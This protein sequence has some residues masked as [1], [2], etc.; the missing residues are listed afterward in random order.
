MRPN[1]NVLNSN[2]LKT[3]VSSYRNC[4][5]G[6]SA[7][8]PVHDPAYT[9]SFY[10]RI[11]NEY[12]V[13]ME[14]MQTIINT[15]LLTDAKSISRL[16][17]ILFEALSKDKSIPDDAVFYALPTGSTIIKK[18]LMRQNVINLPAFMIGIWYYV[19][20]YHT[21]NLLGRCALENWLLKTNKESQKLGELRDNVGKRITR[22][23]N[24]S[25]DIP[26]FSIENRSSKTSQADP[27][28]VSRFNDYL[29]SLMSTYSKVQTLAHPDY[30]SDVL[31]IYTPT[32]L[33]KADVSDQASQDIAIIKEPSRENI[34]LYSRTTLIAGS[35][36][37]GKSVH[38]RYFTVSAVEEFKMTG[39]YLPIV[40][41]LRNYTEPQE[42]LLMF[43]FKQ[44]EAVW[45]YSPQRLHQY[46]LTRTTLVLLDGVDEIP[47]DDLLNKFSQQLKKFQNDYSRAQIIIS[48]RDI[49]RVY[50]S[51]GY[52]KLFVVP[53]TLNQAKELLRKLNFK[54]EHPEIVEDFIYKLETDYFETRK[55][56][57][58]NPLM[59]TIMLCVFEKYQTLPRR[60]Y[61][62][63]KRLYEVMS[64]DFDETKG[65]YRRK[66]K[67][68][69]HSDQFFEILEELGARLY[70]ADIISFTRDQLDRM[71]KSMDCISSIN[72]NNGKELKT[73]DFIDDMLHC[74]CL[75]VSQGHDTYALIH[76]TFREFFFAS[77]L[78]RT[79]SD[80]VKWGVEVI[81]NN[82]WKRAE[83]NALAMIYDM[84]E[85][86]VKR[87]IFIPLLTQLISQCENGDGVLTYI[88]IVYHG[89]IVYTIGEC[90]GENNNIVWSPILKFILE[91]EGLH[92][93]LDGDLVDNPF[94]FGLET[95]YYIKRDRKYEGQL[96]AKEELTIK[97]KYLRLDSNFNNIDSEDLYYDSPSWVGSVYV[98]N[99]ETL[100][101]KEY[102]GLYNSIVGKDSPFY[103]E[104]IGLKKYYEKLVDDKKKVRPSP[105]KSWL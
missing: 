105:F 86:E 75:F 19:T 11:Q 24:I 32:Y 35:G 5:S 83:D 87:M 46:L 84:R 54:P 52:K 38:I 78:E 4:K 14:E 27:V 51:T 55:S 61:L 39:E 25:L 96:F 58:T 90:K 42:S 68:N 89:S 104:Y 67:T 98:V 30:T 48:S 91:T 95:D 41:E 17:R 88:H 20:A 74:L 33:R 29:E 73:D 94:D 103:K 76:P 49:S 43:L 97:D 8:I 64:T 99:M 63:Y 1:H 62:L 26:T 9:E 13:L 53:L 60:M 6:N 28:L 57:A 59:L 34:R 18:T 16:T 71:L 80:N 92:S 21:D 2:S 12:S 82:G 85:T 10:S 22:S 37:T 93:E 45:E 56:L 77:Y 101:P 36:G 44:N 31:K 65:G 47:G 15:F 66:T 40:A 100:D 50:Y 69:L 81:E 72:E 102:P 70:E 3:A 7:D 23:I 79:L